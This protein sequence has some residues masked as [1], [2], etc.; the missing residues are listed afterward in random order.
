LQKLDR[1]ALKKSPLYLRILK[2]G[3]WKILGTGLVSI[4]SLIINGLL[5]R[6]LTPEDMGNYSYILSLVTPISIF[7][8]LGLG[9]TI[10]RELSGAI[11]EEDNSKALTLIQWVIKWGLG[12]IILV[13]ILMGFSG[14]MMGLQSDLTW[15]TAAW[16]LILAGQKLVTEI[17]RGLQKTNLAALFHGGRI[18]GAVAS[19]ITAILLYWSW[20]SLQYIQ[21][22]SALFFLIIGGLFSFLLAA[23]I[24]GKNIKKLFGKMDF[25]FQLPP[26]FILGV[27][28]PVLI[29][30][31]STSLLSLSGIWVLKIFQP[32]SDIAIYGTAQQLT[33]LLIILQNIN[34]FVLS[35]EIATLFARG[36]LKRM[37]KM[38]RR[39]TTL[40]SIPM[41]IAFLF[42]LFG[43]EKILAFLYGD[44]Y[45]IG[46]P[47]VM[48]LAIGI[49]SHVLSGSCGL[50]LAMT[51]YQVDLMKISLI[52]GLLTLI[53]SL[54]MVNYFGLLGAA[55]AASTG[56]II[57]NIW[58]L[59]VVK[60]KIGIWTC[61]TLNI[62]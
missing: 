2:G 39:V 19:L 42:L 46:K 35:P 60:R 17:I 32:A 11:S 9:T 51:G 16:L 31:I 25:S 21:L 59:L 37:E 12:S 1:N 40:A 34:I 15:L 43:G 61:A 44:F 8:G 33:S 10:I 62:N 27:S 18:G 28:L 22:K 55:G 49:I 45:S 20:I 29:H 7:A 41:L 24:L 58:T 13:S 3:F 6:L 38:Q 48:V 26:I 50:T 54:I 56:Y 47:V 4:L 53:L 5:A 14:E 36:E 30:D 57:K 23:V 52:S